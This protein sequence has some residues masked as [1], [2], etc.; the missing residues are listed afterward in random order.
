MRTSRVLEVCKRLAAMNAD[1]FCVRAN[2][3]VA[4]RW[5]LALSRIGQRFSE[6]VDASATGGTGRFFFSHEEVPGILNCLRERLPEVPEEAVERAERICQHRFDLL[7]YEDV[8]YG[9]QIDWHFDAVHAKRAACRPWFLVP[10]LDYD[11]VGDA[12]V[13]WELNRHQH[14][15]ALAKAYR[16][17]DEARYAEELFRQWYD[18]QAQNRYPLGINWAS[19]LEV[20]FRSLSWLWVW[21]LMDGCPVVP[22]SFSYDLQR[23][24]TVNARHIER[25][26]STYFSPNTHLLGEGVGLFFIGLLCPESPSARRW[27]E[28]GW[29]IILREAQRQVLA[30]GVHFEQ[31]TYYH[32]YALDFFL[33]TR[34]LAVR[35][36]VSVPLTF[37]HTLQKMLEVLCSLGKVG[38]LPQ[39]GDDD[40]GRVFD[41]RR[42]HG[43]HM[44][45]PLLTGAVLFN[46]PEL[47]PV[48]NR[49]HEELIWL[50]G[51]N[52]AR[53]FDEFSVG[54]PGAT[55][56]SL[57]SSGVYVMSSGEPAAQRLVLD[58][59][60][61][62]AGRAGHGHADALS[63]QLAI[64][65]QEV[66][67]DPGTFVYVDSAGGRNLFRG[68]KGHSTVVVDGQD[69]TEPAGPFLWHGSTDGSVDCWVTGKSF[70][71]FVGSHGG[72]AR[73]TEPVVH[74]RTVF[75]LKPHFWLVRDVLKGTGLHRAEVSWHFAPGSLAR[76]PGGVRYVSRGQAA[77][78]LLHTANQ[79][80]SSEISCGWYSPVYGRRQSAPVHGVFAHAHLPM[81][82][83]TLLIPECRTSS[84]PH[85]LQAFHS[86]DNDCPVQSYRF[87]MNNRTHRVFFSD[88]TDTWRVGSCVSNA[89]FVYY[90]TTPSD[91]M[92]QYVVCDGSFLEV[93][94]CR[95]FASDL[96]VAKSEGC[97]GA[98]GDSLSFWTESE[99]GLQPATYHQS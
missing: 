46:R 90:S 42:N 8:H 77:L 20:A 21:N 41:S 81:E 47:K 27:Q 76:I 39:F 26:L 56:F 80:C 2:Q 10:Y 11:Q 6:D 12:K 95:I 66:L 84:R 28:R 50:L 17:T 48:T 37:D 87:Y 29:Q 45:D 57:E 74:R 70:D 82:F 88:R 7:G 25:Y 31:S 16:F 79:D 52:A 38:P 23:A 75:Y 51:A 91:E 35:N 69:Q 59:G 1:E 93:N 97:S 33:H 63:V 15:V 99:P 89:R 94:G 67:I 85:A 53:R 5:D 60:P 83:A 86:E 68:T 65:G 43:E 96:P 32:T 64:N 22:H 73:L 4:K 61:Q 98:S 19:S 3:E 9:P 72:Y 58:A 55:S 14:L 40:G 18:W 71:L 92:Y 44:L 13:V 49:I 24:L 34:V 30:D 54:Q 62:G 36:G 78:T